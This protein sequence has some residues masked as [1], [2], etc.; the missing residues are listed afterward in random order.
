MQ[1]DWFTF[2][3]Q[4]VNFLILLVLL[5]Y[6]LFDRIVKVMDQ[7][8]EMLTKKQNEADRAESEAQEERQKYRDLLA[9]VEQE[10]KRKLAEASDE[11]QQ[12]KKEFLRKARED[13]DKKKREW[14][15][16]LAREKQEFLDRLRDR[17]SSELMRITGKVVRDIA[18]EDVQRMAVQQFMERLQ[19]MEK[20]E[21]QRLR[22][23]V[24]SDG[25]AI[26]LESAIPI[27]KDR[28]ETIE[29]AIADLS[30]GK[31]IRFSENASLGLG[32]ELRAGDQR[33]S[34]SLSP[35]LRELE[36][37][38]EEMFGS[39]QKGEPSRGGQD[40]TRKPSDERQEQ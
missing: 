33:I 32:V 13:V 40:E 25:A 34:W 21:K 36:Q 31:E 7:R 11:A 39:A 6:L 18:D 5:K 1:I 35:Y 3:A 4:I 22:D 24:K 26:V 17:M 9:E 2:V 37:T 12:E 23:A 15:Q 8:Q 28:K 10:K 14:E 19:R 16:A 20:D 38:V 29:K 30:K 27:S